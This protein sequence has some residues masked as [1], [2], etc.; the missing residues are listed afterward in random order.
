MIIIFFKDLFKAL[1]EQTE[2]KEKDYEKTKKM[3]N[4][5]EDGK[6]IKQPSSKG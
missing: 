1:I 4:N 2:R 5:K 3:Q 6:E